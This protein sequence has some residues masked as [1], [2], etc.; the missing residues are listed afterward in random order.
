VVEYTSERRRGTSII[1]VDVGGLY[2]GSTRDSRRVTEQKIDGA[3]VAKGEKILAN[4]L[5]TVV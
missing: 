5:D 2:L 3:N 4:E 1:A